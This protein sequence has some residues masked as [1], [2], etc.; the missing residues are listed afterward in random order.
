MIWGMLRMEMSPIAGKEPFTIFQRPG[1][2]VWWMR[3][4]IRGEGQIRKSLGTS[5]EADA[6]RR[7]NK[8]WHDA[9]YRKENGLRAVQR[10]FR[11][12][13]EE[14]CLYMDGLSDRG[15]VRHD[16]GDR[17]RPLPVLRHGQ[18]QREGLSGVISRFS[19]CRTRFEGI[20]RGL[21]VR[22]L[23]RNG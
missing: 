5:D 15:E 14:F 10:T 11:A 21:P 18:R 4:S 19:G 7:A 17:I 9:L 6:Y 8:I 16:R 13:A 22:R 3:F 2:T 1:S 12:V 23:V 20:L